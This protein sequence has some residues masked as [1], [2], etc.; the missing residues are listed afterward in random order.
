MDEDERARHY[1]EKELD[2][3]HVAARSY[4]TKAQIA[5]VGYLLTIGVVRL[6]FELQPGDWVAPGALATAFG[7]LIVMV[8]VA[9]FA[10]VLVPRHRFQL[11][12]LPTHCEMPRTLT[13]SWFE[14]RSAAEIVAE[15]RTVDWVTELGFEIEKLRQLRDRKRGRFMVALMTCAV[16]LL[17]L[18]VRLALA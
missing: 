17:A 3:L 11:A 10:L 15:A 13:L 8:P 14:G 7:L 2:Y 5:S 1:L 6:G 9:L 4:D 16:A 12:A 18:L